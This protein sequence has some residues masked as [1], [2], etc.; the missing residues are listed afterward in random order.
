MESN[1]F[2]VLDAHSFSNNNVNK[3]TSSF[4][5]PLNPMLATF[6]HQFLCTN[7][8]GKVSVSSKVPGNRKYQLLNIIIAVLKSNFNW[9]GAVNLRNG[10][11][12]INLFRDSIKSRAAVNYTWMWSFTT[13][14]E[15]KPIGR[16]TEGQNFNLNF[17]WA[18]NLV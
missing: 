10:R 18:D 9:N 3:I 4:S 2:I 11:L 14:S 8:Y 15:M 17:N 13:A 12:F 5:L 6:I 1:N 7:E 16:W